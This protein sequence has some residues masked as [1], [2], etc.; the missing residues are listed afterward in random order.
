MINNTK[1][2]LNL[3]GG[4]LMTQERCHSAL[5]GPDPEEVA[6]SQVHRL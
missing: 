1:L 4:C 3:T 5:S 2:E 6:R